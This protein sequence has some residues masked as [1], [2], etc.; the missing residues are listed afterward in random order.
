MLT[1]PC[2]AFDQIAATGKNGRVLCR[3]TPWGEVFGGEL[4]VGSVFGKTDV[5]VGGIV[6]LKVAHAQK[7]TDPSFC[8]AVVAE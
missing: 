3:Q 5:F 4:V 2:N 6:P 7:V 1:C 8:D